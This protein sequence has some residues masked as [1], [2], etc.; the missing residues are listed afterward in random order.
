M[1]TDLLCGK[2]VH[3]TAENPET[4]GA[5][6]SRWGGD[7]EYLR[8]HAWD[9][10]QR[11]SARST[12]EWLEKELEKEQTFM[13]AIRTIPEERIIGDV[14]LDGIQ[15]SHGDAWMGI[16]LGE[17]EY[18]GRGYGT[19]AIRILIRYAFTELNLSRLTLDTF[20]YN[21][22]AIRVYEKVGFVLEGRERSMILR[23]GRRWDV[24]YY[25]I[26]RTE[27]M[28]KQADEE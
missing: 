18:W 12:R 10:A 25:G 5:L 1:N 6:L 28:K 23:E 17:R 2:L 9:P 19:D 26:L 4:M 3:L 11:F 27:W 15:W 16:G 8:L 20:E 22:R 13:F 24:L 21:P 7:S 14:E